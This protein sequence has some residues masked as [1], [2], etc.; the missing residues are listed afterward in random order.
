VESPLK[1]KRPHHNKNVLKI[2]KALE[3]FNATCEKPLRKRGQCRLGKE[4]SWGKADKTKSEVKK[5]DSF[6]Q[7][8]INQAKIVGGVKEIN[9]QNF[10]KSRFRGASPAIP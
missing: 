10:A 8:R 5:K 2:Y 3:D 6:Q 4:G 1:R 7:A 9:S